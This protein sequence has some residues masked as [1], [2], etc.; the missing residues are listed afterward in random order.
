MTINDYVLKTLFVMWSVIRDEVFSKLE[1]CPDKDCAQCTESLGV[2]R[3]MDHSKGEYENVYGMFDRKEALPEPD[4]ARI[5][6]LFREWI[7]RYDS[8]GW[9][10]EESN[11]QW[12]F[13][14]NEIVTAERR[15]RGEAQCN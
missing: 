15:M 2:I 8:D 13:I 12:S 9:S 10:Q 11:L 14:E 5:D 4:R 3:W 6:A 7:N 1:R